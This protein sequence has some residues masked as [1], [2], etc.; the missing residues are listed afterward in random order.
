MFNFIDISINLSLIIISKNKICI[1]K[2][3]VNLLSVELNEEASGEIVSKGFV[4]FSS[5]FSYIKESLE[6]ACNEE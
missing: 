1:F 5:I 4:A 6:I 2:C 3:L